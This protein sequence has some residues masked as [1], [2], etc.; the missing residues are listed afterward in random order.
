MVNTKLENLIRNELEK[1]NDIDSNKSL[2][3]TGALYNFTVEENILTIILNIKDYQPSQYNYIKQ[4]CKKYL[5]KL[6][7]K[8]IEQ[9]YA[10]N[11]PYMSVAGLVRYWNQKK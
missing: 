2:V 1:I 3:E 9:Y 6:D 7:E 5:S 4:L 11:P 10:A 8:L